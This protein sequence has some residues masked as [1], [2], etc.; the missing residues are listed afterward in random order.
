MFLSGFP[1]PPP[2]PLPP[3]PPLP[4]LLHNTFTT[5]S[6]MAEPTVV[7]CLHVQ[8]E[9]LAKG[10]PVQQSSV[11]NRR[12]PETAINGESS[13]DGEAM[14]IHTQRDQCPWWEVDLGRLAVINTIEIWNREDIPIDLSQGEDYFTK[15]LF[16]CWILVSTDPFPEG[17]S[18]QVLN[19]SANM[20]V[21]RVKMTKDKRRTTW[22]LPTNS[23]G[24]YV[25]IMLEGTNY[26]HF[27]QCNVYGTWGVHRSVG[28]VSDVYCGKNLF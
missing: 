3:L 4:L 8:S 26:L 18:G 7:A 27:A 17:T 19:D 20:A 25:R 5:N 6:F 28:R 11:Y 1:P 24:R 15:R 13:G 2:P 14:C 21:A 22:E 10:R 23:V 9:S 12:G 16:P